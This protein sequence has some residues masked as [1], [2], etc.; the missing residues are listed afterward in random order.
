M[1]RRIG[2]AAIAFVIGMGIL[3]LLGWQLEIELLQLG[4]LKGP[5]TMK[6]NTALCFVLSGIVLALLQFG[7]TRRDRYLARGGAG[8]TLGLGLLTLSQYLWG[9]DL[10]IDQWLFHDPA[11]ISQTPYPGRMAQNTALCFVLVGVALLL[12]THRTRRN[13]WLAQGCSLLVLLITL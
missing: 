12:L 1:G 4:F 7:S 10:G 9:W 13:I 11:P 3:V 6:A 2:Y 8:L 5:I